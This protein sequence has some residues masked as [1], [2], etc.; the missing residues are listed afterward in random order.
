M[1]KS[2]RAVCWKRWNMIL[3]YD[4][5]FG[6]YFFCAF[7]GTIPARRINLGISKNEAMLDFQSEVEELIIEHNRSP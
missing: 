4:P 5:E 2:I 3:A 6:E 1:L 7:I